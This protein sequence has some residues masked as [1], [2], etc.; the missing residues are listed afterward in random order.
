LVF[1]LFFLSGFF[2][3]LSLGYNE[4]ARGFCL[5]P[6]PAWFGILNPHYIT[7]G[8]IYKLG[9]FFAAVSQMDGLFWWR[10]GFLAKEK[11]NVVWIAR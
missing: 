2:T 11:L 10:R 6:L 8:V 3:Y 9:S 1:F 7:G 5:V 4:T